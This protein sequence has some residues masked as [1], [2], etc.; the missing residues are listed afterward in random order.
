MYGTS[1]FFLL[2]FTLSDYALLFFVGSQ[3]EHRCVSGG[4]FVSALALALYFHWSN[5]LGCFPPKTKRLKPHLGLRT[6]PSV[7]AKANETGR[8]R[9]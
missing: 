3:R 9:V 1:L 5:T 6:E 4:R 8:C 2:I 7:A